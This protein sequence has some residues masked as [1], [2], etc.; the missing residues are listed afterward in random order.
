MISIRYPLILH[1]LQKL[2]YG[3]QP[4]YMPLEDKFILIIK[5]PKEVILTARMNNEIKVYLIADDSTTASHVGL[6]TAFFDDH[7]EPLVIKTY[8]FKGDEMPRDI[9]LLLAQNKFALYFFDEHN[10]ELMGVKAFNVDWDCQNTR[11]ET[12]I[13]T[14]TVPAI[15]KNAKRYIVVAGLWIDPYTCKQWSKASD[16]DTDHVVPLKYAHEHSAANWPKSKKRL[17]AND[18]DHLL[19]VEDNL[20]QAKGAKGPT[21]W[22][23]PR[24]EYRCEY[25][26]LFDQVMVKYEL[27]YTNSE[28][29][30]VQRM[31]QSCKSS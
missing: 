17:F 5:A 4:V 21:E 16:L 18:P 11:H 3:L 28:F 8:L 15:W 26:A 30:V 19:A 1:H 9:S 20:N 23:P 14:S 7:D 6:I 24:H 10:R 2:D 31:R 13:A 12:L 22:M 29:R 27:A 25:L